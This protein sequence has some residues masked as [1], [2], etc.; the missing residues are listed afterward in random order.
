MTGLLYGPCDPCVRHRAAEEG[1]A[2]LA[3]AGPW[4]MEVARLE[5]A[6]A[7]A[8]NQAAHP[9]AGDCPWDVW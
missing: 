7:L 3:G 2:A 9:M 8:A 1:L 5:M 4:D 6:R